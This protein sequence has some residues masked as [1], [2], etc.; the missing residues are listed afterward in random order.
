MHFIL[1]LLSTVTVTYASIPVN[2]FAR[3]ERYTALND[4]TCNVDEELF[5][6]DLTSG[7]QCALACLNSDK[8]YS[9]FHGTNAEK[10]Y[11]CNTVYNDSFQN[12]LPS[13]QGNLYYQIYPPCEQGWTGYMRS[14]YKLSSPAGFPNGADECVLE[15]GHAVYIESSVENEF[16]KTFVKSDSST[17]AWYIGVT[18]C[19]VQ[20][21][22]RYYGTDE[23]VQFTDFKIPDLSSTCCALFF[24]GYDYQWARFECEH[25]DFGFPTICEINVL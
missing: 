22:W 18:E 25:Q 17:W 5:S 4:R 3:F 21:E 6:Y 24:E 2:P 9:M 23:L 14:C 11:G 7:V 13:E 1:I 12:I 10:C 16:L 20:D 8:C 19:A 15:G